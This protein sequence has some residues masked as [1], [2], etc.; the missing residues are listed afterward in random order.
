MLEIHRKPPM[1]ATPEG[2]DIY[3]NLQYDDGV[4][5]YKNPFHLSDA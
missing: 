3:R 5:L 4:I 2:A 1:G